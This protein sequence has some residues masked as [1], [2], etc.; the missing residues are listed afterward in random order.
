VGGYFW[1]DNDNPEYVPSLLLLLLLP[2]ALT[3]PDVGADSVMLF[4]RG[5]AGLNNNAA[6]SLLDFA[7]LLLLFLVELALVAPP[8]TLFV[9]TV[10]VFLLAFL[11]RPNF[12]A[13]LETA[14][15]IA[16]NG[17]NASSSSSSA[18][19]PPPSSSSSSSGT[20]SVSDSRLLCRDT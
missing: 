13:F 9:F 10:S 6:R 7:P 20:G 4:W 11:M 15:G 8:L 3:P 5:R 18:F 16:P 17:G 14:A 2:L 1:S 12:S 19:P